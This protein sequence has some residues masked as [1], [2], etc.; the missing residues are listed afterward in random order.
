MSPSDVSSSALIIALSK[1]DRR[2]RAVKS[3]ES[4]QREGPKRKADRDM[5]QQSFG[6]S[7][8]AAQPGNWTR[9][10]RIFWSF[11]S[12]LFPPSWASCHLGQEDFRSMITAPTCGLPKLSDDRP[13]CLVQRHFAIQRHIFRVS[14]L[15]ARTMALFQ[16]CLLRCSR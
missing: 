8:P 14:Q 6:Q 12:L 7:P 1:V 2:C 16:L 3:Q 4:I 11:P 10:S 9:A 13:G 5:G 15:D